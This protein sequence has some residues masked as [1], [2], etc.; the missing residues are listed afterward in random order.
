MRLVKYP[1]ISQKL[2]DFLLFKT[3]VDLV[4]NKEHL[5]ME[6]IQKIISLKA[7][8]NRGL[9]DELKVAFPET[10]PALRLLAENGQI[11]AQAKSS[12]NY[13]IPLTTSGSSEFMQVGQWMAGFAS[14]EGCF[15]VTENKSSSKVY[16]RLVFSLFQ[17][18]RDKSLI[19]DF[20]NFFDCGKYRT[21]SANRSTVNFECLSFSDN[22]E[23]IIPFFLEYNIR[24]EKSKDFE[25][26][27]KVARKIKAKDHLTE[28]GFDLICRIKSGM[29]KGRYN[30]EN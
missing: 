14:G 1:L 11:L 16:L 2:G 5:T 10:V 17:H 28:E 3:S 25:D 20:V 7:S 19:R 12:D 27:C 18:S 22:Y 9:T 6:G 8:I 21:S 24:G 4:N 30:N 29:N 23:K 13:E 15:A 26:W